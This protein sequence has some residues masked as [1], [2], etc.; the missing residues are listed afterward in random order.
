MRRT[1]QYTAW[2]AGLCAN[3]YLI[4]PAAYG[5][6]DS[7]V[8]LPAGSVMSEA[9]R[10]LSESLI[11]LGRQSDV[12]IVF[13]SR[14]LAG[15][16]TPARYS[17]IGQEP[18]QM[19]TLA[20]LD[21]LL[22]ESGLTYK[23]INKQVIA[24]VA[25]E[26]ATGAAPPTHARNLEEV[27]VVGQRLTGSRIRR[28]YAQSA[29][30]VD[31]ISGPELAASG[32]QTLG[33]F[34]K[35]IPTVAGNSTSTAI[36]NGG[37]GTATVTLRGLP[38]NN[39]LVLL[40]GQRTAYS[41][42]AGDAIDLNSIPPNA[43]DRIEI[44]KDG[45]S[46]VYGSDA[47]A[48]VIN[49]ILRPNYE[50]LELEQFYGETSRDDLRTS[51]TNFLWGNQSEDASVMVSASLFKQG[52]IFS[53]DRAVSRS[54]DGRHQGGVDL[55]STATPD[56]RFSLPDE[57]I[58]TLIN[59]RPGNSPDDYRPVNA[60]DLFDYAAYTS[61]TSPSE[62]SSLFS[63][64]RYEFNHTVSAFADLSY[65]GTKAVITLAPTPLFTRF[66][67]Q[68]LTIDATQAYNPFGATIDDARV[69][70]LALGNRVQ[71]YRSDAYRLNWGLEGDNDLVR[72][73]FNQF[74]S[75]TDANLHYTGLASGARLRN[76]LG[77]NDECTGECVALNLFGG[78]GAITPAMSD[79]IASESSTRGFSQLIG[80]SFSMDTTLLE[81]RQGDWLVASGFEL[82]FESTE[83]NPSPVAID[84]FLIGGSA[85][86][87]T[88]GERRIAEMFAELH[89]PLLADQPWAKTLNLDLAGRASHYSDFG[90]AATPKLGLQY[91]PIR[92]LT[93]RG[94][95]S[96][97]F[98]APSLHEVHLGGQ[99][100]QQFIDDP[101]AIPANVGVLPGCSQASDPTRNQFLTLFGGS[102]DLKPEQSTNRTLG[103]FWSPNELPGLSASS[104]IFWIDQRNVVDAS[105]QYIV[106]HN[107]STGELADRVIRNGDGDIE[108][109][110]AKYVNIGKRS[111]NGV[112]MT[113][114]YQHLI[115]EG[116]ASISL[117]AAHLMSYKDQQS[118]TSDATELAG[119]F[120]DAASEGRGAL[121]QWKANTGFHWQQEGLDL[122]YTINYISPLDETLPKSDIPREVSSWITHD[123]Q[124]NYLLAIQKGLRITL[125]ADNLL[126]KP[127]PFVASAFNDN[128]DP[129]T[130]DLRGRF[131][132]GRLSL[133]F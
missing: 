4:A 119:S 15:I 82:R 114:K 8:A 109:I 129:R 17:A 7:Q 55:R 61:S 65:T 58:V 128:T 60:E 124:F 127:A 38:A 29:S 11:E 48:G 97:G 132:Y 44:L 67:D 126:D 103:I 50:G 81:T 39:T 12:S 1:L 116:L 99:Q 13:P 72:W 20:A 53:R 76:A 35:F 47:I 30:P 92:G 63:S 90:A 36:S 131:W 79:Y 98:R 78:P 54:A 51:T 28:S 84:D 95:V 57:T 56:G 130:Y 59:N 6:L 46:A 43:V 125:G 85:T 34:L 45:A 64:G 75:R 93:L 5:A 121:P 101:C 27:S 100:S 120:R 66:E 115:D 32:A 42:M 74:W 105:A 52:A 89:I 22:A 2:L 40:N 69:R 9:A 41:G 122:H 49:I 33:E 111:L 112:D 3:Q 123:I 77:P 104:D 113:I 107:A 70:L 26:Q 102:R 73:Q 117:N 133:K 23:I 96:R 25:L 108:R 62:R 106:N 86:G 68:P 87:A 118:P 16:P 24:I 19:S 88:K 18:R 91:E 37:D 10:P 21:L 110:D 83:S 80:G 94:T 14:L 31:V 71:T